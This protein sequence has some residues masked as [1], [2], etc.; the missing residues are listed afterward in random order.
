MPTYAYNKQCTCQRCKTHGLMGPAMIIT[1]G[2]LWLL[3]S[4]SWV[5]FDQSW[6]VFML[7]VGA[8]ILISRTSSVEGHVPSQWTAPAT[9][10]PY[11][12]QYAP[13]YQ[14]GAW[15]GTAPPPSPQ[16]SSAAGAPEP[17][18][19]APPQNDQQVNS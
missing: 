2:A 19:T 1:A 13:Q 12:A 8:V 15:T 11:P 3:D 10:Q 16:A 17:P 5:Y 7:V 4:N 9:P 6:P 14:P 18:P